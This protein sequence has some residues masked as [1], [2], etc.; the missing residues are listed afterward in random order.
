MEDSDI[1]HG[2]ETRGGSGSKVKMDAMF[3]AVLVVSGMQGDQDNKPRRDMRENNEH[4]NTTRQYPPESDNDRFIL[5]T[6]REEAVGLANKR[7][8]VN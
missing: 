7:C 8:T 2:E 6:R 4:D 1:D 3:N 5:G